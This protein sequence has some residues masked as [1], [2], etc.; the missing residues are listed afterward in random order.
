MLE[1][2]K[3]EEA[4]QSLEPDTVR[5]YIQQNHN[6]RYT[7]SPKDKELKWDNVFE[8]KTIQNSTGKV[9]DKWYKGNDNAKYMEIS[10]TPIDIVTIFT[11]KE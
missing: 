8:R 7:V 11:C 10:E 1:V 4:I 3:A 2:E 9:I 5:Y 6:K